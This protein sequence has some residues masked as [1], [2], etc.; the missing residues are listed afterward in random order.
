MITD[1]DVATEPNSILEE[2]RIERESTFAVASRL[3]P[4]S[5]LASEAAKLP[6][7][8]SSAAT[9]RPGPNHWTAER[10]HE[11]IAIAA[12]YLAERRG[13]APGHEEEDWLAAEAELD[14]AG[15]SFLR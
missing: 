7:T 3:E 1:T 4:E 12:Y 5:R 15:A 9:R 11:L 13:F 14:A 6:R 2:S 8:P 10:R